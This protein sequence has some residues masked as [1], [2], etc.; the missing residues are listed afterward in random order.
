MLHWQSSIE[1]S[2]QNISICIIEQHRARISWKYPSSSRNWTSVCELEA[3]AAFNGFSLF[4][5]IKMLP[6]LPKSFGNRCLDSIENKAPL[7]L[8][9]NFPRTE[10]LEHNTVRTRC[11]IECQNFYDCNTSARAITAGG[12]SIEPFVWF[13][14]LVFSDVKYFRCRWRKKF[15]KPRTYL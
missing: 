5:G 2:R 9:S 8:F 7:S 12:A 4:Y 11:L 14:N 3:T 13:V 6:K 1:L 10:L 15:V